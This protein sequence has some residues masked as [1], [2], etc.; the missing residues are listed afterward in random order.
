[1]ATDVGLCTSVWSNEGLAVH[2]T[3]LQSAIYGVSAF[4]EY[5]QGRSSV[6]QG[7]LPAL[8]PSFS[9]GNASLERLQMSDCSVHRLLPAL[10]RHFSRVRSLVQCSQMCRDDEKE[11]PRALERYFSARREPLFEREMT[12]RRGHHRDRYSSL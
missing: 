4:L 5:S 12:R 2:S 6:R 1:M 9:F 10:E 8:E 3:A 11:F 7:L